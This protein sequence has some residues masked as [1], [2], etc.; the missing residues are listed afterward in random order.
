MDRHTGVVAHLSDH[1]K[2][3]IQNLLDLDGQM[4]EHLVEA[5]DVR[6][7][8]GEALARFQEAAEE[9]RQGKNRST[10]VGAMEKAANAIE[11]RGELLDLVAGY[12]RMKA[13]LGLMDFSDQIELGARLAADQPE[14]GVAEREKFRVV[15]LDE[16]QDTSVAQAVMLS[17][18]FSGRMRPR[19]RPRG[20]RGRRPQPGDLRVAG[21][22]GLQHP[23]LRRDLPRRVRFGAVIS[24]DGQ[25]AVRPPDPRGRQP[26]GRAALRRVRRG[27]TARGQ[28]RGRR[29]RR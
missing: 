5:A 4:S 22:L 6:R 16:Y 23:R 11:R 25:P 2:T 20:H 9:V 21:R 27:A 12:R 18:L 17:R 1:P 3:V 13:D 26:V 24:P 14:V 8:D 15:L 10:Y 29:G 7:V 28:A 19:A